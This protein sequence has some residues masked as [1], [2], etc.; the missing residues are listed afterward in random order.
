[1]GGQL[2]VVIGGLEVLQPLLEFGVGG[3]IDGLV[4]ALAE[5]GQGDAAVEGADAFFVQDGEE[6]VHCVA[7]FGDVERVRER[8]VLGLEPDFDHF[9]RRHDGDGFGDA[10]A[11]AG[12]EGN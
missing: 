5:G 10:G 9:H 8:V 3:E 11:E 2:L 4:G 1:M 6:A 7:V 12:W